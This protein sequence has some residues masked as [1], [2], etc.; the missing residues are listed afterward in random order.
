MSARPKL[1]AAGYDT[2]VVVTMD[3]GRISVRVLATDAQFKL[4]VDQAARLAAQL[5]V[6]V[7]QAR[8]EAKPL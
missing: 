4:D 6:L 5:G 3:G 8:K 2:V 7:D 1:L